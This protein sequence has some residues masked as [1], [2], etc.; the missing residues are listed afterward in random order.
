MTNK[1]RIL[2]LLDDEMTEK[3]KE[4]AKKEGRSV[5]NLVAQII[6]KYLEEVKK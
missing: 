6:K 1:N 4:Q 3:L 5:S 2:T